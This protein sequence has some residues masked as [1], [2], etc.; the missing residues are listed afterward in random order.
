AYCQHVLL[1]LFSTEADYGLVLLA[2]QQ[3]ILVE[4]QQDLPVGMLYR[5]CQGSGFTQSALPWLAEIGEAKRK[6]ALANS[7]YYVTSRITCW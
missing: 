4:M 1:P 5:D 6:I 2:H 3:N 7:N